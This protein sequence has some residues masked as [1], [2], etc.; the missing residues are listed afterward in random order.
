MGSGNGLDADTVDGKHASE[1]GQIPLQFLWTFESATTSTTYVTTVDES[2]GGY[3]YTF[4]SRY[5]TG[6]TDFPYVRITLDGVIQPCSYFMQSYT[7]GGYYDY[8]DRLIKHAQINLGVRFN[9][10]LKIEYKS[11]SG[12]LAPIAIAYSLDR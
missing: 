2:R 4:A 5:E 8:G 12:M 9:S 7:T 6:T 11:R 3:L 1:L 10:S